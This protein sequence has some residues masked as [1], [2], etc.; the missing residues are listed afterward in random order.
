VSILED[1]IQSR[2]RTYAEP[3]TISEGEE[4]PLEV[5]GREGEPC[6]RCSGKVHRITQGGRST[7]FCPRCQR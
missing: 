2:S 3:G 1:A 7:Y 5:Y 4:F 6:M